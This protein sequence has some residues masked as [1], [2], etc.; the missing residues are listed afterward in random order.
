MILKEVNL[1]KYTRLIGE[2]NKGAIFLAENMQAIRRTKHIDI[3][4]HFIR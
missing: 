2:D 4:F 1:A 3:K